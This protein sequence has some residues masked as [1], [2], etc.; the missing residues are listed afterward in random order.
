MADTKALI[1]QA[2]KL[3]EQLA[4]RRQA[5]ADG[6]Q[7]RSATRQR[8]AGRLI[9]G[10]DSTASRE[11]FW[12]ET[13]GL[14]TEMFFCVRRA[15]ASL[16]V[17]LA[18]YGGQHFS[19]SPWHKDP[20]ELAS[21]MEG[22]KCAGGVTQIGR[23]LGHALSTHRHNPV[24]AVIFIGDSCEEQ[25]GSLVE[26]AGAFKSDNIRL[27]MFDD[28]LSTNRNSNTSTVY[29]AIATAA[30]G[31]YGPFNS[32]SPDVVREYLQTVALYAAGQSTEL[33]QLEGRLKTPEGRRLLSRTLLLPAPG[34]S[35]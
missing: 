16:E 4:A 2:Q 32:Q 6:Q 9:F 26:I 13:K 35:S 11:K 23:V 8:R 18:Y 1:S 3:K 28:K 27:F 29:Q 31:V 15:G 34:T 33:R 24:D 7:N 14:Q 19:V 30:D 17:Q 21:F 25:E 10:M 5:A 12:A 20:A 22:V